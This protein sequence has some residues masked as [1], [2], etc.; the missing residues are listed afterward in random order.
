[1]WVVIRRLNMR[2]ALV[3]VS[4]L[5]FVF[6]L[7]LAVPL[8]AQEVRG[9]DPDPF[10]TALA[11][12]GL[13]RETFTFDYGDMSNYGGDKYALPLFYTL[14]S[15]PF[16]IERYAKTFRGY[17]LDNCSHLTPALSFG[18]LRL[19]EGIRRGLIESPL[20]RLSPR[21][22]GPE[23]LYESIRE[24]QA[25]YGEPLSKMAE[26]KLKLKA[27]AVPLEIQKAAAAVVYTA[28]DS[29][30][31]HDWA[32]SRAAAE[33]DLNEMYERVQ[34][35]F[36]Q[37]DIVDLE[38]ERFIDLVD[39]KYLFT[40]SQDLAMAVDFV[41]D[42]LAD[43]E[44]ILGF[45]FEWETPLGKIVLRG[46]TDHAYG[47]AD[48]FLI[49]DTGGND[50][51][52][53]AAATRSPEN[54]ISVLIDVAGDD[55]Y[56][57]GEVEGPAFGAG[58]FGY[59]Y[60]VDLKGNDTYTAGNLSQGVGLF[61]VGALLDLSG[62]D[63]YDG[64][65]L[66]QGAAVF[67]IGTLLDRAGD[68]RYHCFQ[69]GQ[70]FGFTKGFGLL[71]DAS[72]KDRY[73]A[74]DSVIVFPSPQTGDHNA[75]LAQGVG[76]GKR[77]DFVDGHSW[78]GGIGLLIDGAGDDHYSAGLFAQGCAYWYAIGLLSDL[79]GNDIYD[80]IWY[81]QGSGAHFGLG[82][83]LESAGNDTYNAEINMAQ[84]AGHDFTL[85]LLIEEAGNDVY[86][87]PNLSL[88]GG[89]ANGIGILWDRAGD[90]RYN[91]T[92]A[93]TLG[94]AN[95][96]ARGGLRDH[97]KT[98]GFFLDTGGADTYPLAYPDSVRLFDNNSLWTR[99]GLNTDEPLDTER[100]VGYDC[101]AAH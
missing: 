7:L 15:S 77:A 3:P 36:S 73:V 31:Y 9:S 2:M 52:A 14:H 72:G 44:F 76:F 4:L 69:Q 99:P 11:E 48:Y 70:G 10:A 1:M 23:P 78:A 30:R 20:E 55:T 43:L 28:I 100:G 92:A 60:L 93:T 51:Y 24:F 71:V 62:D 96:G 59:G 8:S 67:G 35:L 98:I 54:W 13:T 22:D 66:T 21:L 46:A 32:L 45:D 41:A 29:L 86:N 64:Y 79:A 74:E 94:R 63:T 84:G 39:L 80:G 33:F 18:S 25:F 16:K 68:D 47:P 37:E 101:E 82:V 58:I 81:V 57:S 65:L 88:G 26:S 42:S 49:I 34:V 75:S 38:I 50:T 53:S 61:G 89:N 56:G 95:T 12:I 83:L 40:P 90:D 6:G 97:I 91:C 5:C 19:D 17:L 27:A 85:G 87:A